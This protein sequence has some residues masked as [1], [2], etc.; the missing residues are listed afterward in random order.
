MKELKDKELVNAYKKSKVQFVKALHPD[1]MRTFVYEKKID[2]ELAENNL[3]D[4]YPE[5]L[6]LYNTSQ[7]SPEVQ[8]YDGIDGLKKVYNDLLAV[9]E[10]FLLIRSVHDNDHP[11]LDKIVSKQIKKQSRRKIKVRALTPLIASTKYRFTELDKTNLVERRIVPQE[12]FSLESQ[13][14][15]YG[16]RVALTAMKERVFTTL[17][18]NDSINQSF[19]VMF[20]Y[21]WSLSKPFHDK[22]VKKWKL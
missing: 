9:K 16:N 15:V 13:I 1:N 20:E 11:H 2:V 12:V 8:F 3:K 6:S 10:D 17:I 4:Y 14:M 21:M 7:D 22:T 19:R 18:I 5:I